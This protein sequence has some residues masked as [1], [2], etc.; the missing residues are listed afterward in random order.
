MD[1]AA[2]AQTAVTGSMLVAVPVATI[3]GLVSFFSPCMVP[4]LP[5]YLSY[6]SGMTAAEVTSPN[7][8]RKLLAGSVLFVAGFSAVFVAGGVIIGTLGAYLIIHQDI[9]NR[10]A[11]V[12]SI[13]MG[14]VFLGVLPIWRSEARIR[15]LPPVGLAGAPILGAVFGLG[16]T[17][18]LG[19]TLSVVISLA[20]TEGST[21]RGGILAFSYAAGM[22]LPFIVAGAAFTKMT[23]LI[24]W[25]R[26]HQRAIQRVGSLAMIGVG[27]LLITGAWPLITSILRQWTSQFTTP[28]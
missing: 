28:L 27:V 4:L 2:W 22:G 17:P 9:I 24:N 3:A 7:P 23:R 12:I 6:A 18:C 8:R 21:I 13:V 16:W 5:G 25:T 10:V 11:G 1:L 26:R 14:L 15:R 20:L 19:P